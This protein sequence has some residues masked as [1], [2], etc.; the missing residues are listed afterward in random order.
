MPESLEDR[1]KNGAK[2]GRARAANLSPLERTIIARIAAKAAVKKR[3][4]KA[5]PGAGRK[6]GSKNKVKGKLAA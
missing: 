4:G 6:P 1:V 3:G 2:G 5:P